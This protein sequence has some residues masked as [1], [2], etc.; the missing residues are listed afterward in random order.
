MSDKFWRGVF[1]GAVFSSL[2]W[3]GIIYLIAI[4]SEAIH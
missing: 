2:L 1:W 4:A 3:V